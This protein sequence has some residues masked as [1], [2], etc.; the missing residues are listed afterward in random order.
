MKLAVT[1]RLSEEEF[2]FEFIY[3]ELVHGLKEI[4]S[5][6]YNRLLLDIRL[7]RNEVV[8][9]NFFLK[10]FIRLKFGTQKILNLINKVL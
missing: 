7:G 8:D 1:S 5:T 6:A 9:Q 3:N 2:V 4:L 10:R